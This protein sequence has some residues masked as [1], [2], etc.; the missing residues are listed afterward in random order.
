MV[1]AIMVQDSPHGGEEHFLKIKEMTNPCPACPHPISSVPH[2]PASASCIAACSARDG[3][4]YCHAE[5]CMS[6]SNTATPPK[7][8]AVD[9]QV[10]GAIATDGSL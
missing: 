6:L 1:S 8:P 2:R 4:V 5:T 10:I 3:A 7:L 9:H